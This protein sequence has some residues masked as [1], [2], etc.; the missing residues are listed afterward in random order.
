MKKGWYNALA[1]TGRQF[2][3]LNGMSRSMNGKELYGAFSGV[4]KDL[5][6]LAGHKKKKA[7]AG[8]GKQGMNDSSGE[9][10][11]SG[12][13]QNERIRPQNRSAAE[14]GRLVQAGSPGGNSPRGAQGAAVRRGESSRRTDYGKSGSSPSGRQSCPAGLGSPKIPEAGRMSPEMLRQAVLWSEILGEPVSRK[15]RRKRMNVNGSK[16][17]ADRR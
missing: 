13:G 8:P 5:A 17:N 10:T 3:D 16:S 15:R 6:A 7:K 1:M 9:E 12:G 2:A 11:L 14:N 4:G